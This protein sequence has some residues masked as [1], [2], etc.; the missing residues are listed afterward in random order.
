MSARKKLEPVVTARGL[1]HRFRR[2]GY[3]LAVDLYISAT[4]SKRLTA[5]IWLNR[6]DKLTQPAFAHANLSLCYLMSCE[7]LSL[8]IGDASFEL[9]PEEYA[10]LKASLAPHGLSHHEYDPRPK[11]SRE[12]AGE[13]EGMGGDA[14]LQR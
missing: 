8:V 7:L 14:E 1:E 3:R 6:G 5:A 10:A 2:N 13:V 11:L 4:G 9:R 12:Y